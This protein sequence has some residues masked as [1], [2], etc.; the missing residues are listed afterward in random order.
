M[1]EV[2]LLSP[3]KIKNME[4]L[5]VDDTHQNNYC[6]GEPTELQ[7]RTRRNLIKRVNHLLKSNK[8][9][10]RFTR[11]SSHAGCSS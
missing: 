9:A 4:R 6:L 8:N 1:G 3:F 11:F 10:K 5:P 2:I 7:K